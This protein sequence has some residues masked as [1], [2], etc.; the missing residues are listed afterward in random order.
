MGTVHWSFHVFTHNRDE[1]TQDILD[2]L[3]F[4]NDFA[5]A[6]GSARLYLEIEIDEE[7][8]TS[9]CLLEHGEYPD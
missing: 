7:N 9:E 2:A 3:E 6:N 8:D 1:F 5:D 4:F